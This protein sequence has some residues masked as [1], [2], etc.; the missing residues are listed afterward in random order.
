MS[1]LSETAEAIT[2]NLDNVT[3]K[4]ADS[5]LLYPPGPPSLLLNAGPYQVFVRKAEDYDDAWDQLIIQSQS[6]IDYPHL[7]SVPRDAEGEEMIALELFKVLDTTYTYLGYLLTSYPTEEAP[8]AC[9]IV[10]PQTIV[11][12]NGKN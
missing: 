9:S 7:I 2:L 12:P 6:P 10:P 11:P 8:I 3:F 1:N 4:G 5:S